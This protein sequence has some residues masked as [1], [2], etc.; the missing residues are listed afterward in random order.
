MAPGARSNTWKA[1]G[2]VSPLPDD[3]TVPLIR[4]GKLACRNQALAPGKPNGDA[5]GGD[6]RNSIFFG[7]LQSTGTQKALF[8]K[9]RFEEG[10]DELLSETPDFSD[11]YRM[12]NSAGI[13]PNLQD[14][15]P[16]NWA[17]MQTKIIEE[18]Y[19]L[20]DELNPEQVFEKALPDG[21]WYIINEDFLKIYIEY[22]KRDKDGDEDR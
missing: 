20:L 1:P 10:L 3:A 4:Q 11:A 21:P 5:A 14:A 9:P 6:G 7:F 18:G 2:E 16:L 19:H 15:I 17:A 8:R 13:F 12:L 22:D